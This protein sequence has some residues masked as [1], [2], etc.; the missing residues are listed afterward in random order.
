MNLTPF[1][2][3]AVAQLNRNK[4]AELGDRTR[5]IGSSDVGGCARMVYLQRKHPSEPDFTTMLKFSRGHV[6][7]T[8]ID[9]IFKAAG[10]NHLYDTQVE[11]RHPVYP[12]RAHVDFLFY[13]DFDNK[14]VLHILELKSVN[15]IPDEPYPHWIDQITFQ[16][17][18]LRIQYPKAKMGGSILAIDLNAGKLHQFN[19]FEHN[20][21]LCNYL[22]T[23]GLHMIDCLDD[24]EEPKASASHMCSFCSYRSDCPEMNLPK[25]ELPPEIEALANKYV[26]LNEIRH[27]TDKE[28]Q[29]I[30]NELLEF[31]GSSF[32]G[33]SDDIELAVSTVA[34]SQVVDTKLLKNRY[35]DI[36]PEVLKERA[37]YTKLECRSS[38]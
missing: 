37:G 17:G 22:F 1:F 30:R 28:L 25:V 35:P 12:L 4:S 9:D 21:S 24:K 18:L 10:I 29:S 31:T 11:L 33:R 13:A 38:R 20:D 7:E 8:L 36:Y 19:G 3:T 32:K 6:A 34:P 5:Y 23:R 27:D 14:P 2:E 16:L 26:E 15:N